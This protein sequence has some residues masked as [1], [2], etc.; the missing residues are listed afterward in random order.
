MRPPAVF[1]SFP[2]LGQN[3]S[4]SPD[5]VRALWA[6]GVQIAFAVGAEVESPRPQ[7]FRHLRARIGQRL[8]HQKID[9]EPDES[10]R[11]EAG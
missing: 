10:P 1:R 6:G 3:L 7:R 2:Q 11:G 5:L 8:A 4:S 9:D